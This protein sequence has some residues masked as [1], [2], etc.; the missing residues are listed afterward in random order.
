VHARVVGDRIQAG[1]AINNI[2]IV[3]HGQGRYRE[4][5]EHFRSSLE[6][7]RGLGYQRGVAINYHNIAE[8]HFRLG[9]LARAGAAFERSLTLARELGW[10][11]GIALNE[12]Y[13]AFL[14]LERSANVDRDTALQRLREA[15]QSAEGL[16]DPSARLSARWLLGRA[17]VEAGA[18]DEAR[19]LGEQGLRE[20]EGVG[21][22][23]LGRD[24]TALLAALDGDGS[25]PEA[26]TAQ[27]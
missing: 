20:A 25:P 24:F 16:A 18:I 13:I 19:G 4:A 27:G 26:T 10:S 6:L 17:L 21:Y 9:D 15:V 3:R 2:G 7:R 1:K 11:D 12:V 5:L 22:R 8:S 23:G 14:E